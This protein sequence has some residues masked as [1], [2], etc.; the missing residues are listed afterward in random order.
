[1]Y[2]DR[3]DVFRDVRI[4]IVMS[5]GF[6]RARAERMLD[7][8][9]LSSNRWAP[10]RYQFAQMI[11]QAK[12]GDQQAREELK[13]YGMLFPG[14]P[15]VREAKKP[16]AKPTV[17]K[18]VAPGHVLDLKRVGAQSRMRTLEWLQWAYAEEILDDEDFAARQA[19]AM[20]AQTQPELDALTADL[21]DETSAPPPAKT[22][23]LPPLPATRAMLG[24]TAI[25]TNMVAW[26]AVGVITVLVF[27]GVPFVPAAVLGVIVGNAAG[28]AFYLMAA[29]E[30]KTAEPVDR[31]QAGV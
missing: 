2:F 13:Y 5:Y 9:M 26:A 18:P 6:S 29:R 31:H 19:A 10:L 8:P 12:D 11:D 17:M 28:F 21:P 14:V 4:Q 23:T 1:M 27:L 7:D 22:E 20:R 16:E 24:A 3:P 30:S 15:Q 25:M